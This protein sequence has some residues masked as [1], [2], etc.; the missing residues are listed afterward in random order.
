[1]LLFRHFH[2]GL[3]LLP[4]LGKPLLA[5]A[6]PSASDPC[7]KVAGLQFVDPADAIACQRSFP[8]DEGLRQ[9]V[10]SVVS[11]VFDFYTF[12]DFYFSL[13]WLFRESRSNIRSQI[14]RISAT[15]YD[16]DYSFNL[17]LWDFTNQLNDG[18]TRWI[19]DCYNTYQNILPAPIVL[20]G[21]GVFIAPNSDV[22]FDQLGSGFADYYRAKGFDWKRLAGA[23]VLRIGGY[24]ARDYIHKIAR[25]ESGNFLDHNVR[26]NSVVSSYQI[27]NASLSQRLGDLAT[28]LV[29]RRTSLLF[30]LIPASSTTGLPE[31]VN[32]PFVA[33]FI[34]QSFDD[35]PSYWDNNCVATND[36]NGVD[37]RSGVGAS[38]HEGRSRLVRSALVNPAT[39]SEINLGLPSPFSPSLPPTEGSTG[40]VKSFLLP[41]N[42]TGVMFVGSFDGDTRQFQLDVQAAINQF[43]SSGVTNLLI[44]VTNNPGGWLCLGY[45]LH[46]Y[47]AGTNSG[48]PGFQTA[49]RANP[50]AQKILKAEIAQGLNRSITWYS[51]DNWLFVNGTQMPLDFNYNSPSVP[52]VVN[53]REDPTSQRFLDLCPKTS[54]TLPSAPP[55]DLNNVVIVGNGNCASTCATFVTLMFERHQTKIV[56][57]GGFPN[58]PIEYK[59]MSGTQVFEWADL[60]SEIKTAGLENDPLAPPDLYGLHFVEEAQ[61]IVVI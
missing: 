34:G 52:N 48:L 12:E 39:G 41:G 47:L 6:A 32:V 33:E 26:V 51:P 60:N 30:T 5:A 49:S 20:L 3:L 37:A 15:R 44:D 29:L 57:F 24:P 43:K 42:K 25:T 40:T 23:R 1:M 17:A 59:G 27:S 16:S 35:G 53:G 7:V 4:L 14:R 45:F 46:Q 55:F 8:F 28:S 10:L 22:L 54:V 19:P 2:S 9:N 38:G 13:P 18:H 50:F 31:K 58:K 61:L 11:R 56:T 36:T 21:E